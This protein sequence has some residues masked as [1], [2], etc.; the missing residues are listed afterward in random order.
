MDIPVPVSR[1][2]LI[3]RSNISGA[4]GRLVSGLDASQLSHIPVAM[5]YESQGVGLAELVSP[6]VVFFH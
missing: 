5:R 2:L 1:A 6:L 4:V 3:I